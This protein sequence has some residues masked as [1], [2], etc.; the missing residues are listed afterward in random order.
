MYYFTYFVAGTYKLMKLEYQKQGFDITRIK[1]K[2]YFLCKGVYVDL[3]ENL[4]ND[5]MSKKLNL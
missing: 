2:I 5:I 3:D 4:Y 1:D